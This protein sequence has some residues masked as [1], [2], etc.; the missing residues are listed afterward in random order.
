M[1]IEVI[2][3]M[4]EDGTIKKLHQAGF[5]SQ[6]LFTYKSAYNHFANLIKNEYAFTEAIHKTATECKITVRTMYRIIATFN[7]SK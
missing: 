1:M 6:K 7:E 2:N 4:C 5:I 3:R